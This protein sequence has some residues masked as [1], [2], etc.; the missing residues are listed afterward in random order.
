MS[1]K[2]L[3]TDTDMHHE[4]N[5]LEIEHFYSHLEEIRHV[6]QLTLPSTN[7][8]L[9]LEITRSG[10]EV[11]WSYYYACHE[12][13]C[14]FWLKKFDASEMV[15]E[16]NGVESPAHFSAPKT[17]ASLPGVSTDLMRRTSSGKFL[18]VH[19]LSPTLLVSQTLKF[20]DRNHW[21]IFPAVFEGRSLQEK[22]YDELMGVLTH[23]CVGEPTGLRLDLYNGSQHRRH[24]YDDIQVLDFTI[25]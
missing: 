20:P 22:D 8:D 4:Q 1:L 12:T 7:Y 19:E 9:V 5:R 23:G 3:F 16:V 14:L 15:S 17:S 18:L 13:R 25:R 6:E 24:R 2:R 11:E 10:E 21:S